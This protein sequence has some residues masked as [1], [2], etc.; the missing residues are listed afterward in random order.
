MEDCNIHGVVNLDGNWGDELE[1][2]LDHFDRAY[3]GRFATFCRLD[4]NET[5]RAGWG[6][7]MAASTP[8]T[9][10]PAARRG[11]SCGRMWA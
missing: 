2:N 8:R 9:R 3:P 5:E 4:W 11:S 6:D 1:R 7:R 10:F